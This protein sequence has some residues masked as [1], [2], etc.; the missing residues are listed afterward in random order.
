MKNTIPMDVSISYWNNDG[1]M[2]RLQSSDGNTNPISLPRGEWIQ[3]A[4]CIKLLTPQELECELERKDKTW[5]KIRTE[6]DLE[7]VYN[8]HDGLLLSGEQAKDKKFRLESELKA[9]RTATIPKKIFMTHKNLDH[10]MNNIK[11]ILAYKSWKNLE[12]DG[13]EFHFFSDQECENFILHHFESNV[14]RAY[15]KCRIPVMK[16]DLWRYCAVYHYG[17]IYADSD[18]ILKKDPHL[19]LQK[20]AYLV[21]T[22][23]NNMHLC[24]WVFS[25]PARSPILKRII[26][27]VVHRIL[28]DQKFQDDNCIHHI[29]GPG[30]FSDGVDQFLREHGMATYQDRCQY[31]IY[32]N[33]ALH[34]FPI[35]HIHV[36]RVHH[37][38][39]GSDNKGWTQERNALLGIQEGH[40]RRD[41][42]LANKSR[43]TI[44]RMLRR[45]V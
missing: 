43:Q 38:F 26:D 25:A 27:L 24:Q 14:Y 36:H 18:A 3:S 10:V 37:Q 45:L 6:I 4:R 17:G 16:A 8:N 33:Q 23:E 9:A 1:K 32:Q 2:E 44:R 13:Y 12:K 15:Q 22:P 29:T 28:F 21:C 30:A 19:W 20:K 5:S 34:C 35:E 11:T 7:K 41:Y 39:T 31:K 40:M 42:S